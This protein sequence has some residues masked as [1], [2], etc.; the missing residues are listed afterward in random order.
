MEI[1]LTN[2][3][4]ITNKKFMPEY[5][6]FD[7]YLIFFGGGDSGKSHFCATKLVVRCLYAAAN[8]FKH[9]FLVTRKTQPAVRKSAFE[10]IKEKILLFNLPRG[11]VKINQTMLEI[12]IFDS[13]IIFCGLD[14][15]EKIKSIEGITGTWEEEPTELHP[16]DHTQ[17][18]LRVRGFTDDYM[19]MML[20]FN[21]IDV[22]SWLNAEFFTGLTKEGKIRPDFSIVTPKGWP[23]YKQRVKFETIIDGVPYTTFATCIHST[24]DDNRWALPEGKAVLENLKYKDPNYYKVYRLGQWGVLRGLI[25]EDWKICN[26]W[27]E[28]FDISCYGLDFGY[29]N[30]PSALIRIG[31]IE[32][33]LYLE[34]IFYEKRLTN[35]DIGVKLLEETARRQDPDSEDKID[36]EP[37]IADCAEPKSIAEIRK[38]GYNIHPCKKGKDSI[39]HGIHKVKQYDIYVH[40]DSINLQKELRAYKWAEDKDGKSLNKPV[41]FMDH[42]LDPTRY[43]VEYLTN[44][45][46]AGIEFGSDPKEERKA[47]LQA[48]GYSELEDESLW[49]DFD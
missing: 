35:Q 26:D 41:D 30:H 12:R 14:D 5:D 2:L 1:D 16:D 31:I 15:R 22:Q 20:S 18:D 19:Q 3:P 7:R 45:V 27:P 25:Y 10:L 29:T 47:Q 49:Q 39:V 43:G 4:A 6:N 13:M 37:T 46:S 21:P 17:L 34:E 44:F 38:L 36:L 8:G 11:V 24:I 33:R 23:D 40:P 32:D 28:K 42:L 48:D 9:K